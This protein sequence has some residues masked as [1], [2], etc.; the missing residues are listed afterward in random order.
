MT[1]EEFV[2]RI[3]DKQLELCIEYEPDFSGKI[4][5]V[6]DMVNMYKCNPPKLKDKLLSEDYFKEWYKPYHFRVNSPK[7]IDYVREKYIEFIKNNEFYCVGIV[8]S[9]WTSV[10]LD[11][12]IYGI[13]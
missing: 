8:R 5:T 6:S 3:F 13:R 2:N 11:Y 9:K 1:K 12:A 4:S 7:S 10:D